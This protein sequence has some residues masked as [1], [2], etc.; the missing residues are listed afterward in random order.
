MMK[1]IT[2]LITIIVL[3]SL[4]ICF[5]GCEEENS[6]KSK[7]KMQ[8]A[9][10]T[11]EEIMNC[12]IAKDENALYSIL[13]PKIQNSSRTKEEIRIAFDFIDGEIISYDL[14]TD[15]GGGGH[16]IREGKIVSDNMTP[17]IYNVI[18]NSGKRYTIGFQ[19]FLIFEEDENVVGVYTMLISLMDDESPLNGAFIER[20]KIGGLLTDE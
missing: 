20:I 4:T 3:F 8:I 11:A 18:T 6:P 15:T 14:P 5:I 7:S 2:L 12:F 17:R 10:D 16:S 13:S 19:Y 1:K 9:Q